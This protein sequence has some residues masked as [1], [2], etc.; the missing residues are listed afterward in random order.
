VRDG[1]NL[2]LAA[3]SDGGIK[4]IAGGWMA[5]CPAHADGT[6]S[7]SVSE[8]ST[9]PVVLNC[10][11]GCDPRDILAALKL[12]WADVCEERSAPAPVKPEHYPYL[13]ETGEL[14]YEV[15]RMPGKQFRQR[16]PD[17]DGGWVWRLDDTRRVIFRLPEVIAAVAAGEPVFVCEG[18][19]DVQ[20]I[21]RA[22]HVATCNSGGAGK[23]RAE[24]DSVFAN[25]D[26]VIV[27][28]IDEPG[29]RHARQVKDHLSPVASRV[30][31]VEAVE[32]K[33][34]ADHLAA[35]RSVEEFAVTWPGEDDG[36]ELAPD[37]YEFLAGSE[38]YDWIVPGLLE[39]GDRLILTG[40]EGL[41]K[42]TM[43]QQ[44][45]VMMAAGLHPFS[46]QP[47]QPVRVLYVDCENGARHLRRKLRPLE[48]AARRRGHPVEAGIWRI[49]HKPRG[50]DLAGDGAA[51]LLERVTL[52]KPDVLFIGPLYRLHDGDPKDE[53]PARRIAAALDAARVQADC[54]VV[55][56]A[57][58]GHGYGSERSV[59]PFGSSLWLRWP[60]FGLGLRPSAEGR[61]GSVDVVKWRGSRD[62]RSWPTR[63]D[64]GT[65]WPWDGYWPEGIPNVETVESE[66]AWPVS[67]PLE[68]FEPEPP[69]KDVYG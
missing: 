48:A 7:L 28:D 43:T 1:L 6:P 56:E 40:F 39:R 49:L 51:W 58:A 20:A 53:P 33:D 29:Q 8:G 65:T 62:E 27:A 9:Q 41:G 47:I 59:R 12:S 18:E 15:V 10:H 36:P 19:K 23:W 54:A 32:G 42:S 13:N 2:V 22:G 11:A 67:D 57:H 52:H 17:G 34:A 31:I 63:L 25:A 55:I 37:L 4:K 60:E 61:A 68:G 16:R 64:R 5:V 24:Y 69:R 35:G 46:A 26:V 30:R 45:A 66:G 21:E 50:I 44:L 14:L 38:S 3:L